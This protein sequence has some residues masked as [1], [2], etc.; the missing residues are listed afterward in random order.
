[1]RT[2]QGLLSNYTCVPCPVKDTSCNDLLK[3][4]RFAKMRVG[5]RRCPHCGYKRKKLGGV[6]MAF[7]SGTSLR[8]PLDS[9]ACMKKR[10][11]NHTS[12]SSDKVRLAERLFHM[13]ANSAVLVYGFRNPANSSPLPLQYAMRS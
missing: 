2:I 13:V 9:K 7:T 1:M 11:R 12:T 4:G 10:G 5:L 3:V 8:K 6:Q